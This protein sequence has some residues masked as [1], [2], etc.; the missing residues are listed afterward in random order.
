MKKILSIPCILF[1]LASS[2]VAQTGSV[3]EPVR[4]IGGQT[5]DPSVHEGRLR[6]AIGTENR[7]TMRANRTH[8][9]YADGYGWTYNH[10]SNLCYWNN[11]FYQQYL[12]N[13]ADEHVAPGQTLIVKSKDGR[14][15]EKPEV[16]FPPYKA[17]EGVKIPAGY[18]GYMMH[19][20]MGFYVA[21]DGRLLVIA[22]YGHTDDPFGKGGIGRVVR[23]AYKDGS[24]GPIYFIRYESEANWNE[25]NTSYPFY[26]KST[27]AG[28][29]ASCDALL[30]DKLMT[31]QW[32]DEDHGVD[33]FYNG[34]KSGQA[35]SFYH[36]KDGKVV[37]LWKKSLVAL[38]DDEGKTFSEPVKVPT[39]LMSGGKQWGQKTDDG[40]YAISYNPIEQ[41]QY[42]FPLVVVTGE[43]GVLFDN[44]LLIQ[45]EVPVRRFTGR[46]KD[47]GPCYMRGIEEGNGNPPGNDMWLTYTVNKED[48]WV[49]RTPVPIQYA[50]KGIVSDNFDALT[51]E[52]AVPNWNIYAPKWAPIEVVKAPSRTGKALQ[53][54]DTDLYDYARAIRVFQEGTRAQTSLDIFADTT[55]TGRL[56]IDLTDQFGNRPVRVRFDENGQ[57]IAT[58]GS[59]E[60]VVS[61][62]QKGQWYKVEILTEANTHGHY[63][64]LINGKKVLEKAQLAEAVKSVERLSLRTGAYRNFPNR[65]TPNETNDPP[66]KG[67]DEPCSPT[68]FYVDNV[69][70]KSN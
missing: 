38:S 40:R 5:V 16:V 10:A 47:F 62:Y 66:L 22:F 45:G 58:D 1:S 30:K 69:V 49:S 7:Q 8:P 11:T 15:W 61:A 4:Y 70:I 60:K 65:Q 9:E 41:T 3:T 13:P 56:E 35:L 31:F 57:I 43:D 32:Y 23:E 12:S 44:M 55:N 50:V 29:V 33:G 24:Y 6:Y 37:A 27:D 21:P 2:G 51:I 53:L 18:H 54:S 59:T 17:P 64:L 48:V 52:G 14:H 19:Q 63:T 28:F 26:K 46:W 39:F 68:A 36:R 42:R 25:N 20:R 67:A 34:N